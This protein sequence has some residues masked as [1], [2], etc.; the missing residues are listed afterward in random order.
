MF[1]Y[2]AIA[3]SFAF[4][5]VFAAKTIIEVQEKA[6]KCEFKS[7]DGDSITWKYRGTQLDG[8]QFSE[9]V[10]T[11]VLGHNSMVK[12]IDQGKI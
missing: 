4:V 11:A 6:E 8:E 7:K 2:Y 9:G 10:Y 12:G 1:R 3:F 5:S